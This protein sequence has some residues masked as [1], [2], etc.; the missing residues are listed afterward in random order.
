MLLMHEYTVYDNAAYRL[1]VMVMQQLALD[2][3][4][5]E[6][7]INFL[8]VSGILQFGVLWAETQAPF[9]ILDCDNLEMEEP[10]SW[11]VV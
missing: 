11:L 4:D 3:Q 6:P 1:C 8:L 7:I 5:R 9:G 10:D 2:F